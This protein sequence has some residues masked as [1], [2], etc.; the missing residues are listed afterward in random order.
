MNR[1]GEDHEKHCHPQEIA[2]SGIL[3]VA[4]T[5]QERWDETGRG[6]SGKAVD[7]S[8]QESELKGHVGIEQGRISDV[9]V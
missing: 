3:E 4:V 8:R 2:L 7:L 9:S 6:N 5:S 1:G